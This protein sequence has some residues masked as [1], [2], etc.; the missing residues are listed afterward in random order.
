MRPPWKGQRFPLRAC[1]SGWSM[2]TRRPAVLADIHE[3]DRNPHEARRAGFVQSCLAAAI[4]RRDPIGAILSYRASRHGL[5][6]RRL[7]RLQV[8]ADSSALATENARLREELEHARIECARRAAMAAEAER[9]RW[10]HELHDQTLQTLAALQVRIAIAHRRDDLDGWRDAGEEAVAQ[11]EGE[12]ANLR[13]IITG[14]RP[15]ALDELGLYA[16]IEALAAHYARNHQLRVQCDLSGQRLALDT[17]TEITVYRVV[18]EALTNVVK[19]AHARTA[20]VCVGRDRDELTVLIADDGVG[21]DLSLP[22]SGYGLPGIRERV[23]LL[24]GTVAIESDSR[25]STLRAVIPYACAA[26]LPS[27]A[28]NWPRPSGS[29]SGAASPS[30]HLAA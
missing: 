21:T 17:E 6:S 20:K 11:I 10:A 13:A 2:L 22:W 14:L 19:H 29:M 9:V 8:L 18:Q 3:D 4:G 16:A 27:P 30:A 1:I 7:R 23:G 28:P 15:P 26:G 5:T 25:G 24:G 12:I